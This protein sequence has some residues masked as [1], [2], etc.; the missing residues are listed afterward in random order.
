MTVSSETVAVSY[1]GNGS[2]TSFSVTFPFFEIVVEEVT[3]AGVITEK[4]EGTH[5]TVSGGSGST[6]TVVMGTAPASGVTLRIRRVTSR[7]Q[8]TDYVEND[9]FPAETHEKALDRLAMVTQELAAGADKWGA[10]GP[11]DGGPTELTIASGAVTATGSFHL[12]DTQG[13]ASTDDLDTITP[14]SGIRD[15][16]MLI[17]RPAS[18][19]RT[20]VVKNGTGNITLAST[21]TLDQTKDY[22]W[23]LYDRANNGW[24]EMN[25]QPFVDYDGMSAAVYDPQGIED[26]VFD[27]DNMVE[28]S[29]NL[30]LTQDERDTI[31]AVNVIGVF[32][33]SYVDVRKFA[34]GGDITA[35]PTTALQDAIDAA[36]AA[37]PTSGSATKPAFVYMPYGQH[38]LGK[39]VMKP[40]VIIKGAGFSATELKAESGINDN[41]FETENFAS[42]TGTDICLPGEGVPNNIGF[43]DLR[44]DGNKSNQSAGDAVA[45]LAK[46][47]LFN[48]VVIQNAYACGLKTQVGVQCPV[49]DWDI[50]VEGYINALWI[51]NNGSHGWH[52]LGPHDSFVNYAKIYL[53]G[54]DG[55]RMENNGTNYNSSMDANHIHCYA[56]TG[57]GLYSSG[58]GIKA[59]VLRME[60][61]E[62]EGFYLAGTNNCDIAALEVLDNAGTSGSFQAVI[63]SSSQFNKIR[64]KIRRSGAAGVGGIQIAGQNNDIDVQAEG[65]I[66]GGGFSTGVG[67][68][69][70]SGASYNKVAGHVSYYSGVGGTGLR[71]GNGG[72]CVGNKVALQINSCST[73]FNNVTQGSTNSYDLTGNAA[74]GATMFTGAAQH[75]SEDWRINLRDGSA[76][77]FR[78]NTLNL[79]DTDNSHYTR[80][81]SG[82]NITANRTLTITPGDADRTLNISA[83]DVT[84]SSQVAALL[85]SSSMRALAAAMGIF[86]PL[87][88]SAVQSSPLT[89]TTSETTFATVTIPA[90][91][92]GPN[93]VIRV[94]AQWTYTN[95]ANA[96]YTRIRL[97]GLAG[98]AFTQNTLTTTA[99]IQVI[100][101]IH[102]VNSTSSQKGQPANYTGI[103]GT[104]VAP[105]TASIDTTADVDLVITGQLTNTGESM[106]LESY[107]VEILY[108]A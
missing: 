108:G 53:N 32:D 82:S 68:D 5:Y 52:H 78:R 77:L 69:L 65:D 24:V 59:A 28:G 81:V 38:M 15:G 58:A 107:L 40:F 63:D 25:R 95:S 54:G 71:T 22:L 103:G 91:A 64:A 1:T 61:N 11:D 67:V 12:I 102:N 17:I 14:W 79:A 3:S 93:G 75:A 88:H 99:T 104:T 66:T 106:Y 87:G 10:L 35:D 55:L 9:P 21:R 86:Y 41:L 73:L 100:C 70:P 92:L 37:I 20:I 33:P 31:T 101:V 76:N 39:I 34:S 18:D 44:I 96:K 105:V 29:N 46:N 49:N 19:D 50:L 47:L 56:N 27:M 8:Q 30:I 51:L 57:Y 23:L 62:K 89:G 42:L 16:Q 26:D 43:E 80:V 4:T 7:L 6:G 2:T 98:T 97:N 85:N 83:A 72:A 13:D 48:R 60:N 45:L 36:S 74:A 94:T 90:N 84:I